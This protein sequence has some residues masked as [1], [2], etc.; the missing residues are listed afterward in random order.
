M[1]FLLCCVPY[2]KGHSGISVYI[3]NVIAE[4]KKQGHELTLIVEEQA[5]GFFPGFDK[6]VLP[7][8]C[9]RATV[10][11]LYC[12]FVLRFKIKARDYDRLVILAANR[13][14]IAHSGRLETFAVVHDL[15]QYH[16]P[17]KYDLFRMCYVKMILPS[18]AR[19][20]ANVLVGIS[21]STENDIALYWKVH[22]GRI[23]LNYNG[24][25]RSHL[26]L[27]AN[28]AAEKVV[29]YVSRIEVPGK[30]HRNLIQAWELLPDSITDEYKLVMA[31]SDWSGA[32]Q[33]HQQA[34]E[35][36]KKDSI[37]LPG[38]ITAE[39]L[40]NYY[41]HSVLYVFPSFFEGFG[42]SLIEA[43]ASGLVCACSNNSSLGEIAGDAAA[44]FDPAD[45]ADMAE[46]IE[47]TLIDQNLRSELRAH[48]LKREKEFSWERH[49][50]K[51]TAEWF[52]YGEVF[53]C[54]FASCTMKQALE[55]ID[56]MASGTQKHPNVCAFINA[57][58]LNQYYTNPEYAALL[59]RCDL[60]LPD[61]VGVEIAA[62]LLGCPVRENVNG[63]D[64]LPHLCRSGHS[65]YLLGA[66]PGVADK[67]RANLERDFPDTRILG[68]SHGYFAD[69]AA[70][71]AVIAD[72]NR[73]KPD[74][75]LVALGVPRQEKWIFAHRDEL[76]CKVAIGVGG[77]FDFASGR[78]PRAPRWMLKMKI[79]WTYRLYNEPRRLFKRY[80][81]G[82]PL[83][84]WRV[85][86]NGNTPKY[87][88]NVIPEA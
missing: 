77:L 44:L 16:I 38:F 34:A 78:I 9:N 12:F 6:I 8:C 13:R 37:E 70:E 19:A 84:L 23:M 14:M 46:V 26:P 61:G 25:D 69:A 18:F 5:Q 29:F 22:P 63:T 3:N 82:N 21:Q 30:N 83:F 75:L 56:E 41:K 49:V 42:L 10:S 32:E 60:V 87:R 68:C 20:Y 28:D 36:P 35:S 7:K 59:D 81:I 1:K 65:L 27:D 15:S 64:M 17:V 48:G 55:K 79:E 33:I 11:S 72:I 43:M 40:Y 86:L 62:R 45:P 39:Q 51:L 73:V 66:A 52:G 50:H 80:I 31:G 58:C 57:D 53:G 85:F 24:I 74:I 71:A 88:K 76:C 54:R 67:A 47:R 4:L 2:D